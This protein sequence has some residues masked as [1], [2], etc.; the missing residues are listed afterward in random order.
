M[1][2]P[3]GTLGHHTGLL[4]VSAWAVLYFILRCQKSL[5]M[6]FL[7]TETAI[8]RHH[9]HIVRTISHD[10]DHFSAKFVEKGFVTSDVSS[11]I[12]SIHG[13]GNGV[14]ATR[15]LDSIL[16]NM[17]ISRNKPKWFHEFISIFSMEAAYRDLAER[18]METYHS[19]I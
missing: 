6:Y 14:K 18:M 9:S 5:S 2:E 13:V 3:Q 7:F 12:R 8:I 4:I 17:K 15:L 1:A 19:G 10:L 16:N 11:D